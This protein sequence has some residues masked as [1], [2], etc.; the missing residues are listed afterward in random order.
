MVNDSLECMHT[1]S[2]SRVGL[3]YLPDYVDRIG[4]PYKYMKQCNY[5][6]SKKLKKMIVLVELE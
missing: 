1:Y 4:W 2:V 6:E 3:Q 5:A